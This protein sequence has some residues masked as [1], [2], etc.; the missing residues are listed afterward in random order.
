M[1]EAQPPTDT[2]DYSSF[3]TTGRSISTV[4]FAILVSVVT[5]NGLSA[6]GTV[7]WAWLIL[8]DITRHGADGMFGVIF[9]IAWVILLGVQLLF[10]IIPSFIVTRR[11]THTPQRLR[12]WVILTA[13]AGPIATAMAFVII[14]AAP[15]P[16]HPG[17]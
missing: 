5:L 8:N 17:P 2:F 16:H 13:F 9:L 6:I 14:C 12:F 10:T 4:R 3:E 1:T 15:L 11:S 7:A